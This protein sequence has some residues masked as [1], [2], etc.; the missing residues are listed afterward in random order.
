MRSEP[1]RYIFQWLDSEQAKTED[2]T[3]GRVYIYHADS[4]TLAFAVHNL[5]PGLN[6]EA[7]SSV[8]AE[9]FLTVEAKSL[10]SN[11][12]DIATRAFVE[13]YTDGTPIYTGKHPNGISVV[14]RVSDTPKIKSF[15]NT[16][17][18]SRRYPR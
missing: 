4:H 13:L 10:G 7:V 17:F 16:H 1:G 18:D 14:A 12:I 2:D 5:P 9:A 8:L 11:H 6:D 15:P 3:P